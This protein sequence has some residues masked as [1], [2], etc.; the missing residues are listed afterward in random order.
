MATVDQ[1]KP[2]AVEVHW[3]YEPDRVRYQALLR[4]IFNPVAD[5]AAAQPTLLR[6]RARLEDDGEGA[7][8][9]A[10]AVAS[11]DVIWERIRMSDW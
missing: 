5:G 11:I 1:P 3:R 4:A 2:P 6:W 7:A 9:D 8:R 10:A